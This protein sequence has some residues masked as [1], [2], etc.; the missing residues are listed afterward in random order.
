[1][2]VYMARQPIFDRNKSVF[3]YEL[4]F[5][6]GVQACFPKVDMNVATCSVLSQGFL[7]MDFEKVFQQKKLFINFPN[8]LLLNRSPML[9]PKDH[10]VVEVLETVHITDALA[11]ALQE[12]ASQGYMLAL[13][14]FIDDPR[15]NRFFPWIGIIKIDIRSTPLDRV[16]EFQARIGS[17]PI[18]LLAEK[19]ETIDEFQQTL[20]LGFDY[21]QGYFFCKPEIIQTRD[22][23]PL[24]LPL[25][26]LMSE[27]A[28]D[29]IRFDE[30]ERFVA[31]D[32]SISYKLL[33]YINSAY[34]FRGKE[35]ASIRQALL[36]LGDS[37]IRRFIPILA[38]S[39]MAAGKPSE[40]IRT[41]VIRA[42]FC[43]LLA[44][45]L[46]AAN[47]M[48]KKEISEW[49][50]VGLFSVLDG[51]MDEPMQ[52]VLDRIVLSSTIRDTLLGKKGR[53]N[54]G[55]SLIKA[56]EEGLWNETFDLASLLNIPLDDLPRMYWEAVTWAEVFTEE[57]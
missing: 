26:Q 42:K 39:H 24:R 30:V 49:F 7:S 38:M 28:R 13:D 43:E 32:V 23:T 51:I 52:Q 16:P 35:I 46:A 6:D 36:R 5:R 55:L 57:L 20:A 54:D 29:E 2:D 15:W 25:I 45:E 44:T 37:G 4:L 56:Y 50:L 53:M 41:G 8:D 34:F 10:L 47:A 40:L 33:H 14:D 27:I 3:G 31:H 21:F 19:V 17:Y 12:L 1:M 11:N 22:I 48:T 9:F 18:R